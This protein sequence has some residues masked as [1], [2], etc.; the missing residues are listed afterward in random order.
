MA[1]LLYAIRRVGM[2]LLVI[3]GVTV[4]TFVLIH[5]VP[6]DPVAAL[7]GDH[8]P[9]ALV[10]Q[11]RD[12]LG[13]NLPLPLQYTHYLT[14]LLHGQ[15]GTSIADQHPVLQDLEQYFPATLELALASLFVAVVVGVPAGIV[16]AFYRNRWP[17]H[18]SRI[19]SLGGVS[20]PVFFSA[21]ILLDLFYVHLGWL[22]GPGELGVYVTAPPRI[23]GMVV[24]DSMLSAD[25]PALWSSIRHL[26]LP[27]VVLGWNSTAIITRMT[28]SSLLEVLHLDY[29][30]T[31]R[32]KGL[33]ERRVIIAHALRNALIPTVTVL[34][35]AF[36]NLLQGAVLTET[37]FSWPGIGRYATI[38]VTNLDVPA[39]MGVTLLAALVYSTVNV[40]TDLTY[41]RLDPQIRFD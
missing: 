18:V 21:L 41:A 5:V 1:F 31:A 17:D 33:P 22:P 4:I 10:R 3:L 29:I 30:R 37:I 8:A 9:P 26:L 2:M 19:L 6:A 40:L 7:V 39:I 16:S 20:L 36:G 15:L 14:G 13:L 23:T 28:R 12:S 25:W 34:G 38:S 35:L 32:S 24:L 11:I 27:A